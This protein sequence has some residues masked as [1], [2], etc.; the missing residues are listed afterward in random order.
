MK[1][2]TILRSLFQIILLILKWLIKFFRKI[3]WENH[4]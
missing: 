2:I 3:K 1:A 4:Y